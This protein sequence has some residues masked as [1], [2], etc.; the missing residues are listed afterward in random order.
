LTMGGA[1][2][3]GVAAAAVIDSSA[4]SNMHLSAPKCNV[5]AHRDQKK[6]QQQGQWVGATGALSGSSSSSKLTSHSS[7]RKLEKAPSARTSS[8]TRLFT[9]ECLSWSTSCIWF[10]AS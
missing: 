6:Q 9:C 10:G 3:T 5:I 4:H 8:L 2:S 7:I 1:S